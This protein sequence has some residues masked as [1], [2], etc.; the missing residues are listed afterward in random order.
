MTTIDQSWWEEVIL[1]QVE[2]PVRYTGNE[3]NSIVKPHEDMTVRMAYAF[4]DVYEVGMSHLGT[5]ILYALINARSTWC[6]ERVFC[7]WVDMQEKMRTHDIALHTLETFTP[8]RE[9]DLL[10]FTLQYEMS[11]TNILSM[12]DL[13]GIPLLRE[14]RS[15]QENAWPLV[16]GGGPC[17]YNPEPLAD[18]FDLFLIGDAEEVLPALLE[19]FE[20][21]RVRHT[22][23]DAFLREAA[24]LDGLYVPE[25]YRVSYGPHG[26]VTRWEPTVP[27]APPTVRKALLKRLEDAPFP[28]RPIVPYMDVIH[29]RIMLEVL[30]GCTHGCR[31]CQ[32]GILYRPVRERSRE[33]LLAQARTLMD[34]TGHEDISLT[35]LSTADHTQ[36]PGILDGLLEFCPARGVGISL[37]SLRVDTFSLGMAKK[38]SSVRKTGL[39]FAPEAGSQRLRDVINKGVCEEDLM[40]VAEDAFRAGWERLKLYFMIGLPFEQE[41]DLEDIVRLG[42]KVLFLGKNIAREIGSKR[43]ISVTLSAS[44][45]VPKPFTPFQWCAQDDLETLQDKQ[46]FLR[47]RVRSRNLVF[48]YHKAELSHM[49]A[50]FARGDRRLGRVLLRAY[51]LGCAFDGWDERFRFDLWRLAF[52]ECGL[53]SEDFACRSFQTSDRLPWDFIDCGVGKEWMLREYERARHAVLTPDCREKGCTGCGVCPEFDCRMEL[54]EGDV[55]AHQNGI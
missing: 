3:L 18:F 38:I 6:F 41:E 20:T 32:A 44:S 1:P 55:D 21:H 31:F 52:E 17:A 22:T 16:I 8:V 13:A 11:Y 43:R 5:Q 19:L 39:T 47:D 29:D 23:R 35:S 50:A 40:T 42:N 53:Q 27:Q 48:N 34:A 46:R 7:P 33:T 26:N 49:E 54:Q 25:F 15:R 28:D 37:P 2:K 51:R 30:R 45:F 24:G 10:G 14:E 9:F 4:P 36:L 12:L